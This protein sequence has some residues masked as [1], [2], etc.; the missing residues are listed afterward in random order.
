MQLTA[1]SSRTY[2]V[3]PPKTNSDRKTNTM[4]HMHTL[5]ARKTN[6]MYHMERAYVKGGRRQNI[7][8][9]LI[10]YNFW[11]LPSIL[12]LEMTTFMSCDCL[13]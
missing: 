9:L 11:I 13:M 2:K 12:Q 3:E 7:S 8:S 6:T 5:G 10:Y 4:Y 1:G